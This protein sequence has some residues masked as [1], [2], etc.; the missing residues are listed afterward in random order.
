MTA[1]NS[2]EGPAK[3]DVETA[4]IGAGFGGLCMAIA[5]KKSGRRSF[6][7]LEKEADAGGTWLVNRYPGCA[8]DVP[9]HLYSYSFELNSNWSRAYSPQPEIQAYV[10]RCVDKYD[11]APHIRFNTELKQAQFDEAAGVWRLKTANGDSLTA[12]TLVGALGFLNLPAIPEIPGRD[13]FEGTS[14]HSRYW[15]EDCDLTGKRVA[16]IGTGASAIQ[17]VPQIAP[18]VGTMTVFQRTPPWV[19]PKPDRP[20]TGFEHWLFRHVPAVQRAIRGGIYWALECLAIPFIR[21]PKAMRMFERI[22]KWHMRRQVPD[23]TL[24]EKLQPSYRLGCKRIL[25]SNDYYPSLTKPGV[26][27]VTD[28][29][30]EITPTG[31]VTED[32]RHHDVDVIIYG[33][34]FKATDPVPRGLIFGSGKRD[35]VDAWENGPEAY[36]GTAV[37]GFPNLF[38]I[39]GP[40]TGLGHSSMIFMI[41]SQVAYIAEA[42]ASLQNAGARSLELKPTVQQRYNEDIQKKLKKTVW[43]TGGCRS[44]YLHPSGKNVTLW[45]GFTWQFRRRTRRFS[46]SDYTVSSG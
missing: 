32:G 35:I 18:K 14:F 11:L 41:E 33:T 16:V 39:I 42:V 37:S 8:C 15:N 9:S 30:T 26:E 23:S 31:I 27:V 3:P 43:L 44:W 29:V 17:F 24:R 34:G 2:T 28:A 21:R 20:V 38:F 45:P 25:F 12:R 46:I 5:L 36:L 19:L 40:N 4:I 1:S 10:Q 6:V 7:I 22:G 13:S